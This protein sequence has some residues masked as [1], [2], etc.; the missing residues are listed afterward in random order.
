MIF[1][2]TCVV[3][4]RCELVR[5]ADEIKY[6]VHPRRM[7]YNRHWPSSSLA[8]I[9]A[10]SAALRSRVGY[11]RPYAIESDEARTCR[12]PSLRRDQDKADRSTESWLEGAAD[13]CGNDSSNRDWM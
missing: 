5:L 1:N 10:G 12:T 9:C 6:V 13:E 3:S 2:S 7:G 8:W 4:Y 11:A